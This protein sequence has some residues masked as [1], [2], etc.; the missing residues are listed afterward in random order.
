MR[1]KN[2][3]EIVYWCIILISKVML[4]KRVVELIFYFVIRSSLLF[5]NVGMIIFSFKYFKS[6]FI[7]YVIKSI[8][9]Y[10]LNNDIILTQKGG[11]ILISRHNSFPG[12]SHKNPTILFV[13]Y[14]QKSL[15]HNIDLAY[16]FFF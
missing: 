16:A 10:I 9:S 7:L 2:V 5:V 12:L 4:S 1:A 13:F 8:T 11:F 3:C 15:N 6:H 14:S